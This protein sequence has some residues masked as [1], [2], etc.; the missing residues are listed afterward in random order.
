MPSA[1]KMGAHRAFSG[2]CSIVSRAKEPICVELFVELME[3]VTLDN[4]DAVADAP[5]LYNDGGPQ[6]CPSRPPHYNKHIARR[7]KTQRP[8]EPL[9]FAQFC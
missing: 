9:S 6:S 2:Q 8:E 4:R 3:S 7:Y 5:S 1:T